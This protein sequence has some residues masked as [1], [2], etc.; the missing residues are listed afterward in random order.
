[1]FFSRLSIRDGAERSDEFWGVFK[2]PYYLHQ[3]VWRLF[4]EEDMK[5][6][7]FLY[8]LETKHSRPIVYMVSARQPLQNDS[9][10]NAEIK[11]FEPKLIENMKLAFNLRANPVRKRDGKRHD[12]VM[13]AKWRTRS[14]T[15]KTV[16]V[17][18]A[19]IVQEECSKWLEARA[20]ANGFVIDS[21]RADSYQTHNFKKL[22][23]N[24]RIRFSSCD[25]QGLL[26]IKN[27]DSF[28]QAIFQGIGPAK[29]FG[30]GLLM[31]R[32]V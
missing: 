15:P 13:D 14:Q 26:S 22:K 19:Q 4:S 6:R 9:I 11:T 12:V 21:I 31:V 24:H 10:W 25:L 16:V 29:G 5:V 32:R 2:T 23:T 28:R 8:R 30:C 18:Q 20:D 27:V 17:Q 3:S 1:M 7:N